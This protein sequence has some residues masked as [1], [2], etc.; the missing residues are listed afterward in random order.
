MAKPE[1]ERP[2]PQSQG[3]GPFDELLDMEGELFEAGVWSSLGRHTK[4]EGLPAKFSMRHDAHYVDELVSAKGVRQVIRVPLKHFADA[5]HQGPNIQPLVDSI[6]KLGVLQPLLIRRHRGRYE[7]IAGAKRLAAAKAAG[8]TE[9]PCLLY[10]V[11]DSLAQ[12]M[13]EATNLRSGG[14]DAELKTI[15]PLLGQSLQ[16]LL[17]CLRALETGDPPGNRAASDLIRIEAA[18]AA[19]LTWGATL[20]GF[21]TNLVI[22]EFDGADVLEGVLRNCEKEHVLNQIKFEKRIQRPCTLKADRR[23]VSVAMRGAVDAI[24]PLALSRRK[25]TIGVR[26]GRHE[27]SRHIVLQ[28]SQGVLR[29]P[30]S[31]WN[32]W[33]DLDWRERPGGVASGVGLLA[34]KRVIE[35]HGGRIQIDPRQDGGCQLTLGFPNTALS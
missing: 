7:I 15:F 11:E 28:V 30:D 34:A 13:Q 31:V 20:I 17:S 27:P 10:D 12:R 19:Q 8:L 2:T 35:L 5:P 9:V 6:A 3:S 14:R 1:G 29:P 32:R 24:L 33:F 22:Q 18:R 21:T 16:T 4:K 25:A 26:F 23:L